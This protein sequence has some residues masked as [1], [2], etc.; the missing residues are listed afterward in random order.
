[1]EGPAYDI[2]QL[3]GGGNLSDVPSVHVDSF[4]DFSRTRFFSVTT[5]DLV[6]R[7]NTRKVD[8]V[9]RRR[10]LSVPESIKRRC[11]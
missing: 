8:D 10:L 7:L 5:E 3:F 6:Q 4:R 9:R 1:M 2:G 11:E